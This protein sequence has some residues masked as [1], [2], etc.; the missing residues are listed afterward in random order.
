[1]S[2][3]LLNAMINVIKLNDAI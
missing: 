1:M 3:V 2:K